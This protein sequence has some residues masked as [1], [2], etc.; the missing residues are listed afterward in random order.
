MLIK[1]SEV[2]GA[3]RRIDMKD[4]VKR[5]SHFALSMLLNPSPKDV[6]SFRFYCSHKPPPAPP[7]M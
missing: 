4:K 3:Q 2:E 6:P 5:E 7:L 1:A